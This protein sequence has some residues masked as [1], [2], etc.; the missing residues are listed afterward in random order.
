MST[1]KLKT[2]VI[3]HSNHTELEQ[4]NIRDWYERGGLSLF[5]DLYEGTG[6]LEA[7][8]VALNSAAA[9][10]SIS[11]YTAE[12]SVDKEA[13]EIII[14]DVDADEEEDREVR[15]PITATIEH[16]ESGE[17]IYH[18]LVSSSFLFRANEDGSVTGLFV[19]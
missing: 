7:Y 18:T 5:L 1:S 16:L 2:T 19:D 10:N 6:T 14:L 11:T 9:M 3:A 8:N 12:W 13:M 17:V 4:Q 15:M